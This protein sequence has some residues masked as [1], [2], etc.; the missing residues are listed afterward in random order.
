MRFIHLEQNNLAK[1]ETCF[2]LVCGK[3]D[4]CVKNLDMS[5]ENL[6]KSVEKSVNSFSKELRVEKSTIGTN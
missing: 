5:V 6:V 1:S 3:L 2:G 4:L